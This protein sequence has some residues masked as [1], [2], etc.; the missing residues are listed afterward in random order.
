MVHG[1]D[2]AFL[3]LRKLGGFVYHLSVYSGCAVCSGV[4]SAPDSS[5]SAA[6]RSCS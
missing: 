1:I 4:S 6:V 5:I 2:A 3:I